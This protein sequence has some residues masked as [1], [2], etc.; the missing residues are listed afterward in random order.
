MI[1]D[2]IVT[3]EELHRQRAM[4]LEAELLLPA[5]VL[6]ELEDPG[7]HVLV[8]TGRVV[9]PETDKMLGQ[10]LL[11][12]L[13]G[14]ARGRGERGGLVLRLPAHAL[15]RAGQPPGAP[16]RPPSGRAGAQP[17]HRRALLNHRA[18]RLRSALS[19]TGHGWVSRERRRSP[20]LTILTSGDP[21][22]CRVPIRVRRAG[23]ATD[24][25]GLSSA[26]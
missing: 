17:L 3:T 10:L 19:A 11:D 1:E 24:P 6:E 9:G 12:G 2:R 18:D 21:S 4:G 26:P 5:G 15:R 8:P 23:P 14:Q 25:A 7:F 16:P 22:H 20:G 13:R